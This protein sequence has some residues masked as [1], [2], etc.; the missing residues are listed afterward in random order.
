LESV[1]DIGY[2]NVLIVTKGYVEQYE[3]MIEKTKV[4]VTLI[5]RRSCMM[6]GPT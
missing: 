3:E 4:I 6:G 5:S 2:I 1:V